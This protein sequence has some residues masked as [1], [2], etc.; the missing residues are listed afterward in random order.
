MTVQLNV[1]EDNSKK[2]LNAFDKFGKVF[3][4]NAADKLLE[5]AIWWI[6]FYEAIDTGE[7]LNSLQIIETKNGYKVVAN[8]VHAATVEYGRSPG[9]A[10]PPLEP[11]IKWIK[12]NKIDYSNTGVKWSLM[13]WMNDVGLTTPSSSGKP[14]AKHRLVARAFY[15]MKKIAKQGIEQKPYMRPAIAELKAD[16]D[17]IIEMTKSEVGMS[18]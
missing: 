10:N 18:G 2:W 6:E 3:L 12:R 16:V 1:L 7:L 4:R 11:L 17:S 5:S 14:L 8:A 15:M 13:K 9:S